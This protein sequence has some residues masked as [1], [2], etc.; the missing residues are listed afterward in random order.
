M[1]FVHQHPQT[2]HTTPAS[3]ALDQ[4]PHCIVIEDP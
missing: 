4:T 2:S 3:T 1:Y